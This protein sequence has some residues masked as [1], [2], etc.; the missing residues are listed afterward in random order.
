[1]SQLIQKIAQ[2]TSAKVIIIQNVPKETLKEFKPDLKQILSDNAPKNLKNLNALNESIETAIEINLRV[3]AKAEIEKVTKKLKEIQE[4]LK[5]AK[6]LEKNTIAKELIIQLRELKENI[7][8][9]IEESQRIERKR[10]ENQLKLAKVKTEIKESKKTIQ[11]ASARRN[12]VYDSI[13]ETNARIEKYTEKIEEQEK[14]E[15]SKILDQVIA[16]KEKAE[17]ELNELNTKFQS[18]DGL[19]KKNQKIIKENNKLKKEILKE[20][21]ILKIDQTLEDSIKSD[22]AKIERI[23]NRLTTFAA[24]TEIRA[25]ARDEKTIR[26]EIAQ[27]MERIAKLQKITEKSE[28]DDETNLRELLEEIKN[29]QTKVKAKKI[30]K[31]L[32]VEQITRA[33]RMLTSLMKWSIDADLKINEEYSNYSVQLRGNYSTDDAQ[34]VKSILAYALSTKHNERTQIVQI[35][36]ESQ[37]V[38]SRLLEVIDDANWNNAVL[39]AENEVKY[40]D[41]GNEIEII[42]YGELN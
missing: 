8:P 4:E 13:T 7:K 27:I 20:L 26:K 35:K 40:T 25:S 29:K 31:E 11:K 17:E 1:M 5:I 9:M 19:I 42:N 18:F 21:S 36:G 24:R 32:Q 10:N 39:I 6:Q 30:I 41:T 12:D 33:K 15:N 22:S 2:E 16:K 37:E 23:Q 34:L 38:T 14:K 28:D 3:R